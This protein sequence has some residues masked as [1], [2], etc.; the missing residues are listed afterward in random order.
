MGGGGG[1]AGRTGRAFPWTA[2][3]AAVAQNLGNLAVHALAARA[4]GPADYGVVGVVLALGA[5]LTIPLTAVQA[6]TTRSVAEAGATGAVDPVVR[7]LALLAAASGLVT[8]VVG[9][10]AADPLRVP[11][12]LLATCL[13]PWVAASVLAAGLRGVAI[14]RLRPGLVACSLVASTGVR[15]TTVAVLPAWGVAGPLGP[16]AA[17]ALAEFVAVAVLAVAVPGGTGPA[18]ARLD[19]RDLSG[20]AGPILG[21]WAL[22][23]SDALLARL[24]LDDADGGLYVAASTL[25]KTVLAVPA[26]A[27]AVTVPAFS[28]G[29]RASAAKAARDRALRGIGA[30]GLAGGVALATTAGWLVPLALGPEFSGAVTAT[31]V[32][33]AAVAAT[34]PVSLQVNYLMAR[35]SDR[36]NAVWL[37]ALAQ[38]G[39]IA[40][41]H[42]GP[43]GVAV[44]ALLAVPVAAAVLFTPQ[45]R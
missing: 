5:M 37:A 35:R 26:M 8:L 32:L 39:A 23:S 42:P 9:L 28:L 29:H 1:T 14:G 40:A 6:A 19:A 44:M 38:S 31:R 10:L 45:V 43:T 21:L 7:R 11:A 41:F 20:V 18:T 3:A 2:T 17:T 12:W 24:W 36:A 34:V 16:L 27:I 15:L 22:T 4:L 25:A 30:L 33:A 13:P